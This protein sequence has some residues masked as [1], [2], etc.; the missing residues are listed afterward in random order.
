MLGAALNQP[1]SS[2]LTGPVAEV[3]RLSTL[4]TA[5]KLMHQEM[6]GVLV[7]GSAR[8]H[9]VG[10]VISERDVV[11]AVSDGADVLD[12]RVENYMSEDVAVTAPDETIFAAMDEMLND[13]IRHLVVV[14]EH[15]EV[16][17]VLSMRDILAVVLE[18]ANAES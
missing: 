15:E 3:D 14:D 6:V 1:V 10:G 17:G 4:Q 7:V 12:E 2:I 5:A 8:G 16:V 9:K 18:V 11:R 13:E